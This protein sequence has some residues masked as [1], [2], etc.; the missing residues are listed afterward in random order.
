MFSWFDFLYTFY[1]HPKFLGKTEFI[2]LETPVLLSYLPITQSQRKRVRCWMLIKNDSLSLYFQRRNDKGRLKKTTTQRTVELRPST[3]SIYTFILVGDIPNNDKTSLVFFMYFYR[4]VR[5]IFKYSKI[6]KNAFS[7][8]ILI[9]YIYC[10]SFR[11]DSRLRS[12]PAKS[13]T[14]RFLFKASYPTVSI[15]VLS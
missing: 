12:W 7:G 3:I 4:N 6:L 1:A 14:E 10:C 2:K 5:K 8:Y 15:L 11:R 13:K 9:C